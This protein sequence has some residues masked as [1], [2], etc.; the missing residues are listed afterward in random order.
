[1][2]AGTFAVEGEAEATVTATGTAMRLAEIT[3][4]TTMTPPPITPLTRELHRVVHVV[5][6]I[7]VG[8]GAVFFAIAALIGL[9]VADGFVFAIGVTVALV[10]EAL[11]PTVTLSL[12]WGAEQMAKRNVL[13]R[14]LDAV[15]TLGSTTFV[16]TDKTGTLTRNQMTVVEAWTAD[17]MATAAEPG[18]DPRGA[19]AVE[20]GARAAIVRLALD[21]MRCSIGFVSRIDGSWR[22]HG[23]PM[24]AAIDV[25]ARRLGVDTDADRGAGVADARFPFDP[26]RR[27]MSIVRDGEVIVKGAPDAV[28]DLCHDVKLATEA[29]Q[30]FAGKGL[31]VLA[32]AGRAVEGEVPVSAES[33]ERELELY[34]LLALQDPPRADVRDAIASCRRAGIKVA[35]VTGDH[36]ET[37][38]AIATETG[39]RHVDDP[40][41]VGDDL[42][43][44]EQVLGAVLDRDGIVI[45]RVSP[46][47]K[48][49]IAKALRARGHVVAM[50]GDGVNDGPALHEA[51]VGVAMGESGTDV[52]REASDLILLD[53]H[54]ATI[55]AGHR[56]G[57]GDVPQRS[58][59]PHL[60]PHRQ[61]RRAHA[62]RGVGAV[63]RTIPAGAGRAADHRPRHRHR[64]D[65]GGGPWCRTANVERARPQTGV[66][67]AA[68]PH[69]RPPRVR[70]ARPGRGA[71]V[72]GGVPRLAR[73]RRVEAGRPV[74]DRQ[75]L[76]RRLRRRIHGRRVR[77]GRQRLCL[78]EH[79]QMAGRAGVDEQPA[80]RSGGRRRTG[81]RLHRVARRS[82][83]PSARAVRSAARRVA[84]RARQ[85]DRPARRRRRRQAVA[86][87][88]IRRRS[89]GPNDGPSPLLDAA[90]GRI[91]EL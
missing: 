8:V 91:I 20:D 6:A 4:M 41:L 11:L 9:P 63:R 34:G 10:P 70:A 5:A 85:P 84:R 24:E 80:A 65:V 29:L 81:V 38:A 22:P 69:R 64:H 21:A 23:D 42:P 73:R 26:R 57:Q 47:D 18:Y 1:M 58:S 19:V 39:L 71:H 90:T 54:F 86:A 36:P 82:D 17:G 49:R 78:P 40:V 59:L 66:G 75:R 53:D 61:R 32:V 12:A 16:C 7:A 14:H 30:A 31:R 25:F 72:D 56:A 77:P 55:V 44:D 62:V 45:A 28:L 27:R 50:T 60:S 76:G 88:G 33:A 79:D 15:E 48:L 2:F 35:M 87:K 74:P 37:A 89:F 3:R 46:E 68:Q 83:R 51:D 13:V 52:A 43:D 67:A